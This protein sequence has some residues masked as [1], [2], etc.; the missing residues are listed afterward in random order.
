MTFQSEKEFIKDLYDREQQ[1]A[2]R[3]LEERLT[4]LMDTMIQ[5][6]EAQRR[7]I[8]HEYHNSDVTSASGNDFLN[9][10]SLRR[11]AKLYANRFVLI[12]QQK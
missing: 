9:K 2:E 8:E 6:C 4:E 1:M 11:F 3:M 5:E 7:R 10:K 12:R